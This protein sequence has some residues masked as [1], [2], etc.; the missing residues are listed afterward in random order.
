MRRK[1]PGWTQLT[2]EIRLSADSFR[3]LEP[4]YEHAD[5]LRARGLAKAPAAANRVGELAAKGGPRG[6]AALGAGTRWLERSLPAPPHAERFVADRAPD[7]LVATHL[8]EWGSPQLDY[9][10]AAKRLGIPTCFCV[11]SWDNLTNKGLLHERPDRMTVW[12][13]DQ[14]REAVE[15]HGIPA[16]SI[17]VTGAPAYDHWFGR[18]PSRDRGELLGALGS[19]DAPYVLYVGSS[20]F[21]APNEG[22]SIGRWLGALAR[23]GLRAP[24]VLV[25]P[26]PLN[27]LRGGGP[28]R[29]R[30]AGGCRRLSAPGREPRR[31]PRS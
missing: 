31:R 8:N 28:E 14:R 16:A 23:A 7:L 9:L 29:T 1:P 19:P 15:L 25:R 24:G 17:A 6:T 4:R 2:R 27:P 10:R 11:A 26:H 22:A 18:R 3:Y 13:E 30:G 21:L 20:P 12:N 5:G